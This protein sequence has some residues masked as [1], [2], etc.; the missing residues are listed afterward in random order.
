MARDPAERYP[1]GGDLGEAALVAAGAL[2][3][4]RPLSM[5]ATGDAAFAQEGVAAARVPAESAAAAASARSG[6]AQRGSGNAA[7]APASG[8]EAAAPAGALRWA[9]ALAGSCSSRSAWSPRCT[10]S[11]RSDHRAGSFAS[12]GVAQRQWIVAITPPQPDGRK[13]ATRLRTVSAPPRGDPAG[14]DVAARELSASCPFRWDAG[15]SAA[16]PVVVVVYVMLGIFTEPGSVPTHP[17]GG[18]RHPPADRRRRST[19]ARARRSSP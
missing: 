4:A 8:E 14:A 3:R 6:R 18:L 12:R 10:G 13:Q 1:S 16:L 2:R 7:G 11:R 19:N 17:R 9:I 5:V 15:L